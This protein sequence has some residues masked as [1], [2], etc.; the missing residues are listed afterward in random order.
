MVY[1]DILNELD[2]NF[3][4]FIMSQTMDEKYELNYEIKIWKLI[5]KINTYQKEVK[6]FFLLNRYSSLFPNIINAKYLIG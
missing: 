4:D 3:V 2:E 5:Q 1:K 6:V